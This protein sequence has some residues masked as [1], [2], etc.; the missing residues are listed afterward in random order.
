MA[1]GLILGASKIEHLRENLAACAAD[2]L[3]P[4]LRKTFDRAWEITQPA[5][6]RYFRD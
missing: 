5:C 1:E 6:Q 3:P 4:G 2:P